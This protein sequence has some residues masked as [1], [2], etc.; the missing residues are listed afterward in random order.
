MIPIFRLYNALIWV[1][2]W[3]ELFMAK[4]SRQHDPHR[5]PGREGPTPVQLL[6]ALLLIIVF[7]ALVITM[8]TQS[9]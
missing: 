2:D 3:L 9:G 1:W 4:L 5:W 8:V 6:F 7:G